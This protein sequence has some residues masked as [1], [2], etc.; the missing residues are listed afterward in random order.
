MLNWPV[1]CLSGSDG[2][3]LKGKISGYY[4]PGTF[5]QYTLAPTDYV[6]RIPD[7]LSSID[8]APLLC[9]GVTVHA[10]LKRSRARAGD[11][12]IISGAGGGLGD[13]ATQLGSRALGYRIIGI[14]HGSKEKLVKENGAEAFVDL[15]K[16]PSND[17]G[18]AL[19]EHIKTLTNGHG[20]HAAV[21]CTSANAAYAQAIPMLRFNGVLVC[22]GVPEGDLVPI[23]TA[24]PA[25]IIF[26]QIAIE[27]SAVGNRRDAIEVLDFAARGVLKPH[28]R[29]EKMD[30]LTSVFEEMHRGEVK[31]RVVLDL[32]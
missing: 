26:K 12:V 1:P 23:A 30:K 20:A 32:S 28:I 31:G 5:Q 19:V 29:S 22:V 8:A 6:T 2:L 17:N 21:I 14:D 3:C 15:T 27:G 9:A 11:F 18:A 4:T 7:N 25:P 10:A 24:S 13:L 16:F